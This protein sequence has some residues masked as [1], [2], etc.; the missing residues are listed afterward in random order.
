MSL[1]ML[2]TAEASAADAVIDVGGGASPLAGVLLDRGF[3]DL[4]V[5]DI[6]AAGMRH[7]QARL[8]PRASQVHWLAADILSWH[9]Q[10][11]YQAWHDR[12]VFHFLT[13]DKHRQQYLCTLD[14][15]TSPGAVA[16]FG[17]F[18]QDGPQHCSGLPVARYSPAQ[19]ARQFGPEWRLINQ[20]RDEHIT[21]A[22]AIQPF[23]WIALRRQP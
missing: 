17:C 9:P 19:L 20:D 8:G 4:T 5:L 11:R 2:R 16:V 14:A 21:P 23:T 7:A 6:S 1:R 12:A 22:G 15:A 3:A 18:A 13:A 10:R